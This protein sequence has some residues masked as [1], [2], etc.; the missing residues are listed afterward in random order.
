MADNLSD[1]LEN[2]LLDHSFGK[3]AY[4]MPTVYLALFTTATNDATGGT[5]VSGGSY[6][7]KST[8]GADWSAASAGAITNANALEFIQATASWGTVTH[9]ATYDAP[10]GGNRLWHGPL[11]ASKTIDSGDIARFAAG[12]IDAALT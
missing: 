5:E 12:D 3:T 9:F 6:A 7:R 11:T 10:T 4:T 1:Y 8:A 2:K